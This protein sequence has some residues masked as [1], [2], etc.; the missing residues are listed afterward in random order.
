MTKTLKYFVTECN[1]LGIDR[2]RLATQRARQY[3]ADR[4]VNNYS[5]FEGA[6]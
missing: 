2:I 5:N 4:T 1:V 3:A 6:T